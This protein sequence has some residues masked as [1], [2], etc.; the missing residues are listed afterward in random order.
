MG[1]Q[2]FSLPRSCGWSWAE[3]AGR[4]RREGSSR[5]HSVRKALALVRGAC[6]S[7]GR[8]IFG[9]GTFGRTPTRFGSRAGIR[10]NL[11]PLIN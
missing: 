8:G 10:N 2:I 4:R 3:R 6:H 9:Q 1:G 7:E 11:N 5:R